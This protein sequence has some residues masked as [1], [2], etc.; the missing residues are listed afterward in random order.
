M[1]G[2]GEVQVHTGVVSGQF[3]FNGGLGGKHEDGRGGGLGVAAQV[4]ADLISVHPWHH[5]VED[6]QV[7][8]FDCTRSRASMPEVA[9]ITW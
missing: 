1:D 2:L 7:G 8:M 5:H 9:D 3:I 4:A 6:D